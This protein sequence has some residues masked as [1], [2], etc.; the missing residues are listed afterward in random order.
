MG[1]C[2]GKESGTRSS[3]GNI[4]NV[5]Y[6]DETKAVILPGHRPTAVYLYEHDTYTCTIL[7]LNFQY[8]GSCSPSRPG[9]LILRTQFYLYWTFERICITGFLL[10]CISIK[11]MDSLL[12][13]ALQAYS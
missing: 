9:V 5:L 4:N 12:V 7:L 2:P 3:I 13:V 10:A 6:L 1:L 8:N 11:W